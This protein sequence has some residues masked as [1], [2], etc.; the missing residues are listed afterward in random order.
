MENNKKHSSQDITKK[1]EA[2][3]PL[4]LDDKTR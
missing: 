2:L 3:K 4:L 1:K